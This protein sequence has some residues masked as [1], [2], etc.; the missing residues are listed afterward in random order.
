MSILKT[1]SDLP[2]RT[3]LHVM[4]G[5]EAASHESQNSGRKDSNRYINDTL[6]GLASCLQTGITGGH[7]IFVFFFPDSTVAVERARVYGA[8][9]LL[10]HDYG[11]VKH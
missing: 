10:R 4:S 11:G 2:D 8:Q 6:R 7:H 9:L 3:L 5:A 1:G